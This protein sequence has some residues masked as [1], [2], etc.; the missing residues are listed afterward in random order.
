[1]APGYAGPGSPSADH[2]GDDEGGDGGGEGA[3]IAD[4]SSNT[5]AASGVRAGEWDDNANYREFMKL[6]ANAAGIERLD[7]RDRQVLVVRDSEGKA[8]PSCRIEV[9]DSAGH[10]ATLTTL[11]T[12]RAV[13]FPRAEGLTSPELQVTAACGQSRLETRASVVEGEGVINVTL[14]APRALPARLS[15]EV[16]FILDTTGSMSEEIAAVKETLVQV[17]GQ[18]D[19]LG[20]DIRVGMV[21]FKDRG[22]SYVTKVYPFSSDLGA[23]IRQT[24]EVAAQG[25]GDMPEAVNEGL[26]VAIKQLDWQPQGTVRLAFLIGDAP[27]HVGRGPSYA[28]SARAAVARG[29]QIHTIAASGMDGLGQ[30]VWRQVA[31]YTG[32]AAMFVLR[33]GAGP[34]SVGGGDP[35]SSCGGTQT[36]YASGNLHELVLAKIH[37]A[38]AGVDADPGAIP[39][40][41]QDESARPCVERAV[42]GPET[43][44]DAAP[45]IAK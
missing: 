43:P 18:L 38:L 45:S 22:D 41:G 37:A 8:V 36:Q 10:R 23:F 35:L 13:L 28:A 25:G 9:V 1:M 6:M 39:G 32:G 42:A 29:I 44:T 4:S 19:S 34:Q 3:A 21:A 30:L 15:V 14:P 7:V 24:R 5:V 33:G 20:A 31:Q 27:P 26:E 17:A 16:A 40:L 2:A 11:S 12:G